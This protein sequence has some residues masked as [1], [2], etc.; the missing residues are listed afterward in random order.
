[1]RKILVGIVIDS[2]GEY[3]VSNSIS[4]H[5]IGFA[6]LDIV[7]VSIS[8]IEK[9][10][11]TNRLKS[12]TMIYS[13]VS[14]DLEKYAYYVVPESGYYANT[15]FIQTETYTI[16]IG[17][18]KSLVVYNRHIKLFDIVGEDNM[19]FI[20]R[21]RGGIT[22]NYTDNSMEVGFERKHCSLDTV[23]SLCTNS[24]L[25]IRSVDGLFKS[26]FNG[27]YFYGNYA[28]V[29][30]CTLD[31]VV[32]SDGIEVLNIVDSDDIQSLVLPKSLSSIYNNIANSSINHYYISKESSLQLICTLL[33]LLST[34]YVY[35]GVIKETEI[36]SKL[37]EL[38][39]HKEY[40][41]F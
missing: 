29:I 40:E 21:Q 10:G 18:N 23:S 22:Y 26:P 28:W 8:F 12:D 34:R 17:S 2:E 19:N 36:N 33:A 27:I 25:D 30:D 15:P 41:E 38:Y 4:Y 39:A 6:L 24:I 11:I 20:F 37:H 16:P 31:T 35:S 5:I 13:C 32:I 14:D 7:D 9:D 1:M 3:M